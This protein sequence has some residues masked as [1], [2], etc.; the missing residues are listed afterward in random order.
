MQQLLLILNPTGRASNGQIAV[1][2]LVPVVLALVLAL[3]LVA[4]ALVRSVSVLL[5]RSTDYT[6]VLYTIV[7]YTNTTDTTDTTVSST[8]TNIL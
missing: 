4:L 5:P 3:V 8:G 1:L 2:A 7:L 6:I